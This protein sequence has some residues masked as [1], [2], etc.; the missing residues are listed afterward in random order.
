MSGKRHTA[1]VDLAPDAVEAQIIE[2]EVEADFSQPLSWSMES[3]RLMKEAYRIDQA[4]DDRLRHLESEV[5][6]LTDDNA[7]LGS[8][9]GDVD[10]LRGANAE[11]LA[12]LALLEPLSDQVDAL[13][14]RLATLE[15]L[16]AKNEELAARVAALQE[17]KSALEMKVEML[18]PL[19]ELLDNVWAKL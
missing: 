14:A 9:S 2:T 17:E 4:I 1:A 3:A 11:L 10:A 7:R 6:R 16:T 13:R 5:E 12:R 8:R 15:P 19:A 18:A